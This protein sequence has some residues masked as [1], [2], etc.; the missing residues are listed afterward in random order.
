VLAP[1]AGRV[2]ASLVAVEVMRVLLAYPAGG[3]RCTFDL[4]AG[5]FAAD[6]LTGDG[7]A[8]CGGRA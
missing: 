4:D 2:L 5:A 6:T 3:R 7:C 1:A 8:A